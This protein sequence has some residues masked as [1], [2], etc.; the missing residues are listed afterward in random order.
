MQ[1]E[2]YKL[3]FQELKKDRLFIWST[4]IS[5]ASLILTLVAIAI[6]WQL[7][8]PV[9][10]FF[11]SLPWGEEQLA[12]AFSLF[13]LPG[14]G[15]LLYFLNAAVALLIR[16]LSPFFARVSLIATAVGCVLIAITTIN[17]ILLMT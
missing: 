10:P 17:I 3:Q 16:P 13:L 12:P 5:F 4:V 8:P 2:T 6:T 7:L 11:Y 14:G 1:I 9:I 15:L